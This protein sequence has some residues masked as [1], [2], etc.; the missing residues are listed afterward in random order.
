MAASDKK[1]STPD[2]RPIAIAG[3]LENHRRIEPFNS[4][5]MTYLGRAVCGTH[6]SE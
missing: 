5:G 4:D 6:P 3:G 2:G 1:P